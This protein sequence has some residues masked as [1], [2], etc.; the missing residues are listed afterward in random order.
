MKRVQLKVNGYVISIGQDRCH[1]CDGESTVEVGV[2]NE[3]TGAWFRPFPDM[4]DDVLGHVGV[5]DLV[6]VI[7]AVKGISHD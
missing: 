2:W 4:E 3:D 5:D 1:Y 7:A 6:Q